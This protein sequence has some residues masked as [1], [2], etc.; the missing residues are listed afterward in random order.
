MYLHP[1]LITTIIII[2]ILAHIIAL[3][4]QPPNLNLDAKR[5]QIPLVVFLLSKKYSATI[6]A[7]Q[8]FKTPF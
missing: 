7:E 3:P 8:F 1:P 6:H 4:H 2:I 5:N